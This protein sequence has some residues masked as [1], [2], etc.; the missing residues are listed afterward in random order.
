[1]TLLLHLL[2]LQ[3]SDYYYTLWQNPGEH[4][5]YTYDSSIIAIMTFRIYYASDTY[6]YYYTIIT[7]IAFRT[8]ITL[9]TLR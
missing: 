7:I 1:M 2:L 9:I 4:Y 6:G 3:K 5:Y 8:I